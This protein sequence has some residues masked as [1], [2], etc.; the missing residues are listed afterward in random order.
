MKKKRHFTKE[1]K[2]Q[3]VSMAEERENIAEVA[4]ELDIRYDLLNRWTR[5]YR[6]RKDKA[7]Q[8]IGNSSKPKDRKLSELQALKKELKEIKLE[9]DILKKAISIFS[10]SDG[11][12][13]DL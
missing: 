4:R 7:F 3:A 8:G 12:S 6:Q 11:T 9:R 5:E 13:I 1:F 2:L 10:K